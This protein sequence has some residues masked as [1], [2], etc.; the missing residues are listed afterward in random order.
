[1][2]DVDDA[3]PLS[4]PVYRILLALRADPLH[5][6]AILQ[7][8]E[9]DGF[10]LGTAT[11]YTALARLR[12]DGIV[13]EVD[14]PEADA[15]ARRRYYRLTAAGRLRIDAEARRLEALLDLARRVPGE[16]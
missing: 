12:D 15:D 1:M 14:P 5:G 9:D 7:A 2:T 3:R 10:T 6:Y 16:A 8:V 11:L 13:A 4:E